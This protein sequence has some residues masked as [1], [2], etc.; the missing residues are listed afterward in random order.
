MTWLWLAGAAALTQQG[1]GPVREVA[2]TLPWLLQ[3]GPTP[4][5][6]VGVYVDPL[7]AAMAALV[8]LVAGLVQLYSLGYLAD[9]TPPALGR[10]YL[11]QSLFAFSMLGLVFAP[12]FLQL[13]IF[14]ELVGLCSYLLIGFYYQRP[15]AA[16]AAVKAFWVT[17]L[18]DVG[19]LVGIVLLWGA[20][21]TFEFDTLFRARGQRHPPG[22]PRPLHGA[23]LPRGGREERPV[24]APRLAPRRDGRADARSRR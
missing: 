15:A 1:N 14:W 13:F 3:A 23:D 7:A 24:P 21:G 19:F 4:L 10:Y 12:N 11:Y 16:R 6:T 17:K 9:E 5:A 18:G 2:L 22:Q 20:T 8:A